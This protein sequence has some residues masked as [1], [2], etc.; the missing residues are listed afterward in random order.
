MHLS[1]QKFPGTLRDGYL[2]TDPARAAL[3]RLHLHIFRF[4]SLSESTAILSFPLDKTWDKAIAQR[5]LQDSVG[6]TGNV[7]LQQA[8]RTKLL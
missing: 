8:F 1:V 5:S 7:L 6:S 4:G 2:P 3:T